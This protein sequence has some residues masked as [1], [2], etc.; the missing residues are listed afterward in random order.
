[1]CRAVSYTIFF[2]LSVLLSFQNF[3]QVDERCGG[4]WTAAKNLS[5]RMKSLDET[6][7]EVATC[8][9]RVAQKAL[10]MYR[11]E[12]FGYPLYLIKNFMLKNSVE[13]FFADVACKLWPFIVNKEP[14]MSTKI[15]PAVSVMHAEGHSNDCKVSIFNIT[16]V[17]KKF[18]YYFLLLLRKMEHL[19]YNC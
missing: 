16:Q 7:L 15:K 14:T 11:G 3:L 8:R 19:L 5:R 6:G 10:N 13:F 9:H 12:I 17:L 1:M 18:K 2:L 4:S